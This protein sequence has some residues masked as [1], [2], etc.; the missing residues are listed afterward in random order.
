[1]TREEAWLGQ[2]NESC[3]LEWG[4]RGVQAAAERGDILVVVDVLSFSTAVATAVENG[5]RIYPCGKNEDAG[6]LAESHGAVTAVRREEVPGK[7]RYS[8]S[9][10]TF[11]TATPGERIVLQSPNGATCSRY[12]SQVPC[13]LVGALVNA[14]AV[15]VA[16]ARAAAEKGVGITV[17]ACG[18]RWHSPHEDGELRF[19][20]EDYLG[21]GAIL[22]HLPE[23]ISRSL[24]AQICQSAFAASVDR[25]PELLQNCGSG[26]ELRDRGY[27]SDV[28]HSACLNVCQ[29]APILCSGLYFGT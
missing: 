26:I 19:A 21:A 27:G 16:A 28:E 17:L 3:R 10:G 8:L 12:G 29:T 15:A 5:A 25:L 7:G 6:A 20:V 2:Q 9:P 22:S 18:E 4:S 1:M 14:A 13:L 11:L 24:E 23:S